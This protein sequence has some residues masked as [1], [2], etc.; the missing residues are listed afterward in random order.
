MFINDGSKDKTWEIIEELHRKNPLF[1]GINLSK[2]CGH[3]NALFAG[4]MEVR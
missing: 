2:N 3:Q 1:C 4:L